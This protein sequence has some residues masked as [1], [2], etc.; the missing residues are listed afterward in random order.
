MYLCKCSMEF[1]EQELGFILEKFKYLSTKETLTSK[2]PKVINSTFYTIFYK[3]PQ[4]I[5]N[6]I[7]KNEKNTEYIST[8]NLSYTKLFHFEMAGRT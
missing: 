4:N 6:R 5:E 8:W 7:M 3:S 1:L 2:P